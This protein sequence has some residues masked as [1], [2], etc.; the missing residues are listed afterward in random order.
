M[1]DAK[2]SFSNKPEAPPV[3]QTKA[4]IAE[5]VRRLMHPTIRLFA[6]DGT[7]FKPEGRDFQSVDPGSFKVIVPIK[8]YDE[9]RPFV[10]TAAT[11]FDPPKFHF[12]ERH[13]TLKNGIDGP[14]DG[15]YFEVAP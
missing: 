1:A 13:F 3:E 6:L 14:Y 11:F 8:V 7:E 9:P 5:N 2:F 15:Q 10:R 4:Q 12:E